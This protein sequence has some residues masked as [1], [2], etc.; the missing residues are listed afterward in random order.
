MSSRYFVDLPLTGDSAVLT[1]PEAHHVAHV[2]RAQVGDE[3][4]L[5]DGSGIECSAR[6]ARIGRSAV[7]LEIQSRRTVDREL[8]FHL[9]VAVALPKGD[10]QR[11]LV[12]KLTELGTSSLV[13]LVCSHSAFHASASTLDRLRRSVVES[14]KQC[15]RNRLMEIAAPC[16][17]PQFVT[18]ASQDHLRL[19]AHPQE[20]VATS[21]PHMPLRNQRHVA[22]AV[23]P[24]GGFT[25]AEVDAALRIGWQ[26]VGLGP[27][28]L[29]VETAAV[30]VAAIL[31][32]Q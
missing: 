15:G 21:A 3:L 17:W 27:R 1:G 31:A 26:L 6:V 4:T 18:Q 14:S 28:V 5:F 2:M 9:Q 7:E 13:P 22:L 20:G 10:R 30:A 11:W 25:A 19:L 23:G 24:E 16:P 8:S 29:R 32:L 12:E